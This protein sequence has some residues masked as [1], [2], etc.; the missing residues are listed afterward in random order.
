M[1]SPAISVPPEQP[2][3]GSA[4]PAPLLAGAPPAPA[5]AIS[6]VLIVSAGV[7]PLPAAGAVAID[8]ALLLGAAAPAPPAALLGLFAPA[9][10]VSVLLGPG[11]PPVPLAGLLADICAGISAPTGA[12]IA[13]SPPHAE[14]S[15]IAHVPKQSRWLAIEI[16]RV[17]S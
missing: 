14:S 5:A 12:F 4:A 3:E 17:G 15:R 2:G 7:P 13:G 11:E 16:S 9:L 10:E 8:P 1:L 6:D